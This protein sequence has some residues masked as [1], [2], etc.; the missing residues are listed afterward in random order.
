MTVAELIEELAKYPPDET[1]RMYYANRDA[2]M[3]DL[4]VTLTGVNGVVFHVGDPY[5]ESMKVTFG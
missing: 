1:V 2:N 5:V 3:S 4:F